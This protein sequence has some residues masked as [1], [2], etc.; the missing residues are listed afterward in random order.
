GYE[1]R[2]R[3]FESLQAHHL[4]YQCIKSNK[5]HPKSI[6]CLLTF[7]GFF[8]LVDS[9]AMVLNISHSFMIN[10]SITVQ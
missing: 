1:L 3:E 6:A 8:V 2:G 9:I 7:G 5:E 4:H 10:P